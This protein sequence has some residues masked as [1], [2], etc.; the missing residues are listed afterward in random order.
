MKCKYRAEL[1][2]L[3]VWILTSFGVGRVLQCPTC[4]SAGASRNTPHFEGAKANKSVKRLRVRDGIEP[5]T[6]GFS[7]GRP[8]IFQC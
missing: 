8:T 2:V 5:P 1:M 6:H 7:D 3:N 4:W